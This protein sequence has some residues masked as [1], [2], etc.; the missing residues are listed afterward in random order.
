MSLYLVCKCLASTLNKKIRQSHRL[1]GN[2]GIGANERA[3]NMVLISLLIDSIFLFLN[4]EL[5]LNSLKKYS[6]PPKSS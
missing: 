2:D 1:D 6:H 5:I 4:R 3:E